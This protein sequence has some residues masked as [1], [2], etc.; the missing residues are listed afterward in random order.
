MLFF[1]GGGGEEIGSIILVLPSVRLR[2]TLFSSVCVV[3]FDWSCCVGSCVN[4]NCNRLWRITQFHELVSWRFGLFSSVFLFQLTFWIRLTPVCEVL[5]PAV[6]QGWT[7]TAFSPGSG[8]SR[9]VCHIRCWGCSEQC[10]LLGQSSTVEFLHL[11]RHFSVCSC[12]W[13]SVDLSWR[14]NHAL[15]FVFVLLISIP[16]K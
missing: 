4:F 10:V 11:F 13:M 6:H 7:Q 3:F 9:Y 14:R 2:F 12:V 8:W 5:I 16:M 15:K 1:G